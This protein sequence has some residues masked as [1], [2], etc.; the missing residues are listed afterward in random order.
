MYLRDACFELITTDMPSQLC[1]LVSSWLDVQHADCI[2][3]RSHIRLLHPLELNDPLLSSMFQGKIVYY[4]TAFIGKVRLTTSDRA[5]NKVTDDSNIIFKTGIE[6]NFGRIR[7]IFKVNDGNPV[8][9]VDIISTLT[10]FKCVTNASVY[11]FSN[12]RTGSY[13]DGRSS[14]FIGVEHIVEKCAFYDGGKNICT[15]FRFPN[16]QESSWGIMWRPIT[17]P[18]FIHWTETSFFVLVRK[19]LFSSTFLS[20]PKQYNVR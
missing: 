3:P 2:S 13:A 1:D 5:R 18:D 14:V 12:I 9:C 7:R 10:N 15:F 19:K 4:S 20:G 11:E 16:L 8:F 6:E 17:M